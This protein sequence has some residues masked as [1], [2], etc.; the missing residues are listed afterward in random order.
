[1]GTLLRWLW[2]PAVRLLQLVGLVDDDDRNDS[3]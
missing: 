2:R 3:P 1:V